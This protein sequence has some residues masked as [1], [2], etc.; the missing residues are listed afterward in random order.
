MAYIATRSRTLPDDSTVYIVAIFSDSDA[1]VLGFR[2]ATEW[3]AW[4]LE[5][6]IYTAIKDH[7]IDAQWRR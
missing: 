3:D 7:T 2:C 4:E 1:P 5:T 6:K